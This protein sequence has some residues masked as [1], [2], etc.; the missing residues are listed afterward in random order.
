MCI[1]DSL[2]IQ[3]DAFWLPFAAAVAGGVAG[4]ALLALIFAPAAFVL[5]SRFEARPDLTAVNTLE[6][7]S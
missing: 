5:L 2:L 6:P 4:S 1:R 7:V 3:G